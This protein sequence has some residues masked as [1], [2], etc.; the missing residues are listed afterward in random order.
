MANKFGGSWTMIKLDLLKNYLGAYANVFKYQKYYKLV[1]LDAFAGSGKCDTRLG[2]LEGS[3]KI[4]LDIER[5]DEYIF[6]EQD[7]KNYEKLVKLKKEYFHKNITLYNENCNTII[8][9]ILSRYNW[10]RTRALAF[11]DP[12]QME[13]SF[14]TLKLIAATKAIDVWYL[15]PLNV[16]T[17]TLRKDGKIELK[18]EERLNILL[19]E[20][21]W[22]SKLYREKTQLS[23]FDSEDDIERKNQEDICC[24]FRNRL[25]KIFSS[26]SCPVCLKNSNNA[27]L[28]ALYFAVSN[29]NKKAQ[30]AANRIAGYLIEKEG[31]FVCISPQKRL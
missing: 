5:F 13:L 11:L 10:S 31:T 17:R 29:P 12:Y 27:P 6:I 18:D 3:T 15:F 30:D 1:Y 2:E 9:S 8:S 21:D 25:L 20:S 22:K 16:V 14:E 26:V 7:K 19:G 28:F 24:Y 23:L 4:A